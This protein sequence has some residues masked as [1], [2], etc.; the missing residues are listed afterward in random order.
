[1]QIVTFVIFVTVIGSVYS[2]SL[3]TSVYTCISLAVSMKRMKRRLNISIIILIES[4]KSYVWN[5]T[6]SKCSN[7]LVLS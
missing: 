3:F 2:V 5:C 6:Q 7:L 4:S 1:M